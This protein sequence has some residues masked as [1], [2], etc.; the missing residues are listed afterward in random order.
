MKSCVYKS[1]FIASLWPVLSGCSFS[2]FGFGWG[3]DETEGSDA[4]SESVPLD[5]AK[6]VSLDE[7][8]DIDIDHQVSIENMELKQARIWSR[9]DELEGVL[10]R[11]KEK[12]R[13][14]EKG[15]LLGISPEKVQESKPVKEH[16]NQQMLRPT[17]RSLNTKTPKPQDPKTPKPRNSEQ[18][19]RSQL[20]S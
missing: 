2:L 15:L 5:S 3:D 11:Q 13:I 1:L 17:V 14:L 20:G 18:D 16:P 4:A 6:K 7:E 19:G 8:I 10:L 9:L 12:I